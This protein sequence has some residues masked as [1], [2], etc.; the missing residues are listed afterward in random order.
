MQKP[1]LHL[2]LKLKWFDLILSGEKKE[3]YREMSVYWQRIFLTLKDG[4]K[5]K[6]KHKCY[7]PADV[8]ICFSNGYSIDRKQFY[9]ECQDLIIGNGKPEWGAE[10]GKQYFTLKLGNI[11]EV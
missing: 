1:V 9:I 4:I 11:T 2:N 8:I 7:N 5:I 10:K 6:I 3:E